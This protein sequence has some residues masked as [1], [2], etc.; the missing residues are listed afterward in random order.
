MGGLERLRGQRALLGFQL[1]PEILGLAARLGV[2]I[3]FDVYG[4]EYE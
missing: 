1:D 3:D 4:D 2:E